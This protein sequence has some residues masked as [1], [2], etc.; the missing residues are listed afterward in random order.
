M[1]RRGLGQLVLGRGQ[2]A[3]GERRE[4]L[5]LVESGKD[6]ELKQAGVG[7]RAA[8][9]GGAQLLEDLAGRGARVDVCR[10]AGLASSHV[11]DGHRSLTQDPFGVLHGERSVLEGC[12]GRLTHRDDSQAR[13]AVADAVGD[14]VARRLSH[15][16]VVDGSG[17]RLSGPLSQQSL[18]LWWRG[19]HLLL[20]A[21]DGRPNAIHRSITDPLG[22]PSL[23]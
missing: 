21:N 22:A 1:E 10:G 4:Q 5:G 12:P 16:V 14:A 9:G 3:V 6:D 20:D 8:I 2:V 11:G 23:R 17:A 19:G 18:C 15:P 7:D 13:F